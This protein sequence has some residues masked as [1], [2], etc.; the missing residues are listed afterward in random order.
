MV[1]LLEGHE[2]RINAPSGA[3]DGTGREP[4]RGHIGATVD[5]MLADNNGEQRSAIVT[6]HRPC[7][8][9]SAGLLTAPF[10]SPS[11][12]RLPSAAPWPAWTPTRW[13]APSAPGWPTA[14]AMTVA[15][16]LVPTS[17]SGHGSGRWR[18]AAKPSAGPTHTPAVAPAANT[19]PAP[20]PPDGD[21]RPLHLLACM[22][23][24]SRTVLAQV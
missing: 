19:L 22:D 10:C 20:H 18:S 13:P 21:G 5:P 15:T 6:G 4:A 24:T 23:H 3:R 16:A 7:P 11:R 17:G 12:P 14:N 9:S 1:S 2:W 8:A